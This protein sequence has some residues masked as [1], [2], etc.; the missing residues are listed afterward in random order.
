[1]SRESQTKR[2]QRTSCADPLPSCNLRTCGERSV[3]ICR[4]EKKRVE[5]ESQSLPLNVSGAVLGLNRKWRSCLNSG[6][7]TFPLPTNLAK[8]NPENPAGKRNWF[9][10][11]ASESDTRPL[12]HVFFICE[13]GHNIWNGVAL[14]IQFSLGFLASRWKTVKSE[15]EAHGTAFPAAESGP[16]SPERG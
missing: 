9:G 13:Q 14:G 7:A 15:D 10:E 3:P 4:E 2:K 11:A 5:R 8:E 12:G 16:S 1:M 6:N